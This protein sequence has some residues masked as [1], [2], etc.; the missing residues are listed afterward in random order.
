MTPLIVIRPAVSVVKKRRSKQRAGQHISINACMKCL[1]NAEH[2]Y[3][4]WR[5]Q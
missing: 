5:E 4:Q 2:K 1:I 3:F